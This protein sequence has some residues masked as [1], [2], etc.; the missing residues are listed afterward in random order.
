[1]FTGRVTVS[2]SAIAEGTAIARASVRTGG[3]FRRTTRLV[4][5]LV[6]GAAIPIVLL[7]PT[8][9]AVSPAFIMQAVVVVHSGAALAVALTAPD[10]RIM[11]FAFW[12]FSYVWMGLAPL[13]M[14]I[15]E[16]FPWSFL[17]SV[18]TAFV[19]SAVVE[20]GLLSY[21]VASVLVRRRGAPSSTGL[22][23]RL[24]SRQIRL[25]ATL[26]LA[27]L[28]LLLVAVLLPRFGGLQAA[29]SPRL[30]AATAAADFAE[31]FDTSSYGIIRWAMLV[32]AMWAMLGLLRLRGHPPEV[33]Q[34]LLVWLLLVALVVA[35]IVVNNPISQP[36]YWAG[37]VWLTVVFSSML[38]RRIW[39]FRLGAWATVLS[40]SVLFPYTD[41]FRRETSDVVVASVASQLSGNGD[42]DGYQQMATGIEMVR[43]SGHLP[44]FALSLPF[45]WVP[46][47]V[48]PNKPESLGVSIG[49][50]AG[51]SFTQLSAPL[52]AEAYVW[53]GAIAVVLVFAWLGWLS[54]RLD[55]WHWLLRAN[56]LL[57]AGT[58][59]PALGVFQF[60]FLRGPLLAAAAP[61]LMMVTIPLL[62]SSSRQP[63]RPSFPS[64]GPP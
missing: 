25:P 2:P 35:N 26:V 28:S 39:A 32:S 54:A 41:Y 31:R 57:L 63:Q 44:S 59:V 47:S 55:Q 38:F 17:V 6:L 36:R 48:W 7:W 51:Y 21:T 9:A 61:L 49:E 20:I 42:Y 12:T 50:W 11:G 29:F 58:L 13:A 22:A 5:I 8:S 4:A 64:N 46:R 56:P 23:A 15:T 45:A 60:F 33:Y 43:E 62:I 10:I 18:E 19:T 40:A 27:G 24:L 52:W 16:T 14:L 34:R 1:V 30:V 37:T 3:A 53:G